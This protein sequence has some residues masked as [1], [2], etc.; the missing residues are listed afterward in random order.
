[1]NTKQT[2]LTL[3]VILGMAAIVLV[4]IPA[5]AGIRGQ[6]TRLVMGIVWV[7]GAIVWLIEAII[8]FVGPWAGSALVG[9]LVFPWLD[10]KFQP[11]EQMSGWTD[12]VLNVGVS[13]L[14]FFLWLLVPIVM[15]ALPPA[16][17]VILGP[18]IHEHMET[19]LYWWGLYAAAVQFLFHYFVKP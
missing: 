2:A 16:S 10:E 19:G 18:W 11:E 17:T 4:L 5:G 12:F 1:M 13:V 6:L 9:N 8:L 7:I 14:F 3:A 15:T